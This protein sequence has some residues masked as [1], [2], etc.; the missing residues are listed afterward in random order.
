MFHVPFFSICPFFSLGSLRVGS[1][2]INGGRD[3]QKREL[4][5]EIVYLNKLDVILFSR[6]QV[7]KKITIAV[8]QQA[9]GREPEKDGLP[10]DFYKHF[11][12]VIGPDLH[13]VLMSSYYNN[14]LPASCRRAVITLLL[15]KGDL[16]ELKNWRPVAFFVYRL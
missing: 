4:V 15:N 9:S 8:N 1:L 12:A 16:T 6:N 10:I 13:E 5:K 11:W 14:A 7:W 2:N 3:R